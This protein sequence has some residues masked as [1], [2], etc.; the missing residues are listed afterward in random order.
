VPIEFITE[1]KDQI[2]GWFNLLHVCANVAFGKKAFKN[3][4]MHGYI[5]DTS[6][7]KMSKSLKN[8]IKPAEVTEKFG[9]DVFRMY[10]IGGTNPG[11]DLNYN[12]DDIELRQRNLNVLWNV[13]K[14]AMDLA[15]THGF[16]T[17]DLPARADEEKYIFSKLHSML[18][19]VTEKI[20]AYRLDAIP[21]L[22]ESFYLDLSRT[23]IQLV[24]EKT[25]TGSVDEKQTVFATLTQCLEVVIRLLAP[26]TP[27]LAEQFY[28]NMKSLN[29]DVFQMESVH[30]E[31]FPVANPALI[32][33]ACEASFTL[34]QKIITTGLAARDRAKYGVR[35]P[36]ARIIL[37]IDA[38]L[39]E[40][41]K[42]MQELI[43]QQLNV[44]AIEFEKIQVSYVVKPNYRM[45]GKAFGQKTA[46]VLTL[47]KDK[48]KEKQVADA[49][50]AEKETFSVDDFDFARDMFDVEVIAPPGAT[51]VLFDEGKLELDMN[52]SSELEA[53]GFSREVTR[54]LQN[55][56]KTAGLEKADSIVA[57]LMLGDL[58]EAVLNYKE[59]IMQ[60]CG[61]KELRSVKAVTF[62]EVSQEKVKGK[63]FTL[64]LQKV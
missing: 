39:Q 8:Y 31:S 12:F 2:R 62:Q 50:S 32:D 14:Y 52:I 57:E 7:R 18:Q 4:Y 9:A 58:P 37:D 45:L 43:K 15:V 40:Q 21:A 1:G 54:R 30:M 46:D 24:R 42:S 64:A 28:Q 19:S 22:I 44:K 60:T 34:A 13:H 48:D 27:Y 6:G 5:N 55:L 59:Q 29:L 3:C 25:S 63:S 36:S 35:W 47:L 20:E 11:L 26:I 49:I 23:Y 56:R 51:I 61:A 41:V 53:E 16:T 10:V 38:D 17:L 33:S